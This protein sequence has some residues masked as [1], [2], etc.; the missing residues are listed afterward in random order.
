MIIAFRKC[1]KS[2]V[3]SCGFWRRRYPHLTPGDFYLGLISKDK[4]Y[5]TNPHTPEE[6]SNVRR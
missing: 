5:K 4:V 3:I 1:N 6:L 2:H